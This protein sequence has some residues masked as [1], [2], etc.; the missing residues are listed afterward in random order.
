MSDQNIVFFVTRLDSGGIE[1]YLLRFLSVKHS[2]FRNVFV[3]CKSGSDGQLDSEYL[4][5]DNV[6]LIKRKL[7]YFDIASY[8]DLKEFLV[9]ENVDRKST[10]LNSS[11]VKIS[12]AVFCLKKKNRKQ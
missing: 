10:R 8:R 6:S 12:Y 9:S 1:N 2:E 3:W 11:H 4:K 7:G 5:L